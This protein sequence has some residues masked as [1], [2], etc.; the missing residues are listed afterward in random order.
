MLSS[1]LQDIRQF[2]DNKL[3]K[4]FDEFRVKLDNFQINLQDIKSRIEVNY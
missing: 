2:V 4:N 3:T 1:Q